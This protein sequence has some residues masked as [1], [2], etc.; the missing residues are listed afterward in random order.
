M[1]HIAD[2]NWEFVETI[3][4]SIFE[5]SDMI[6]M[7]EELSETTPKE[8]N[9]DEY[10][11]LKSTLKAKQAAKAKHAPINQLKRD[12][13]NWYKHEAPET[14]KRQ[15]AEIFLKGLPLEQKSLLAPTNAARTL[16]DALRKSTSN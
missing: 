12:F 8:I 6:R 4:E 11:K 10:A 5:A 7:S 14:S 3:A 1:K 9:L 16:L 15:A 2:G 13:I